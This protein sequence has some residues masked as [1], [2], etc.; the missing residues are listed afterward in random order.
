MLFPISLRSAMA[1]CFSYARTT[2]PNARLIVA[3]SY[4]QL[5]KV[6][7]FYNKYADNIAAYY[8][9]V[10]EL[11]G[12][13]VE[14]FMYIMHNAD[15]FYTDGVH[16]NT[17]GGEALARGI[18]S[19][20]NTNNCDVKYHKICVYSSN[21][22]K[23]TSNLQMSVDNGISTIVGNYRVDAETLSIGAND[24]K[25]GSIASPLFKGIGMAPLCS[26]F[27]RTQSNVILP[28][29][30]YLFQGDIYLNCY[31]P[32]AESLIAGQSVTS[33]VSINSTLQV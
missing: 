13:W 24:I 14:N 33:A 28:V 16:P 1:S 10:A 32:T 8:N 17:D 23:Y 5:T 25:I 2:Y 30:T 7:S 18:V 19:Y 9:Y 4:N 26:G 20:L 27:V 6:P 11:G 21:S 15:F 22:T 12:E 29:T 31:T 3:Y